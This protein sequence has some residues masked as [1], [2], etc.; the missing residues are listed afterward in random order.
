M[1]RL[2]IAAEGLVSFPAFTNENFYS[3]R[4]EAKNS[5]LACPRIEKVDKASHLYG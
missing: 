3:S 4:Q 1:A 2:S 5:A